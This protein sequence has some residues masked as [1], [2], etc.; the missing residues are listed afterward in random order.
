[1]SATAGA[2]LG[3]AQLSECVV[4]SGAMQ[5]ILAAPALAN[6]R[7]PHAVVVHPHAD[8]RDA[9]RTSPSLLLVSPSDRIA[10]SAHVMGVA[11]AVPLA[12]VTSTLLA[13]STE[14]S[15]TPLVRAS[16]A[17][18]L[19]LSR[20]LETRSIPLSSSLDDALVSL[21]RGIV[22]EHPQ[23]ASPDSRDATLDVRVSA[24]IEARHT[25]PRLDVGQLARE[26]H[27]SRRQLYRHVGE[28]GVAT[29]LSKRR[30]A[31]AMELLDS[32]PDL[33][34]TD[35]AARSGF[36]TT[37]RLRAQFLRWV[38]QSPTEYRRRADRTTN[39]R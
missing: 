2:D 5:S 15:E 8:R 16:R 19:S 12:R 29:L 11:V 33:S 24:A 13:A 22:N 34:I 28:G 31:T 20:D 26:L 4:L 37:S 39:N 18:L 3:V 9:P 32:R 30:V 23:T 1:M 35:I 21:V 17:L 27:T 38:Q 6:S 14:L 36:T 7:E 10:E 25:D